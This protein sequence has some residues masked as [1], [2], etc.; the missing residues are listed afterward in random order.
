MHRQHA[1]PG[2]LTYGEH[3]IPGGATDEVLLSAHI[4]HPSLANDNLSG[5]SVAVELAR[6]L[7]ALPARR[8][9]YR[10]L[11]IPGTIGSITWLARNEAGDRAHQARAG[12][13]VRWRRRA[14]SPTSAAGAA[15]H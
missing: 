3:V 9:T 11:F 7:A 13:G 5:I 14:R 10:F 15:M 12:A 6:R 1:R 4:C 8:Y 2:A